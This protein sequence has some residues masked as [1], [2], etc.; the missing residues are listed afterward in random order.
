M[1]PELLNVFTFT[2][3]RGCLKFCNDLFFQMERIKRFYTVSNHKAGFIR[4]WHGHIRERKFIMPIKG[5]ML[6][7]AVRVAEWDDLIDKDEIYKFILSEKSPKIL[8][9]P[10]KFAN[11]LCSLTPDAEVIIFSTLDAGDSAKDDF[12][13]DPF[14]WNIWD[15]LDYEG[16]GEKK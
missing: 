1:K 4:A 7:G 14:K 2:D 8:H 3:E 6:V 10:S 5:S 13:F 11:G 12:R 16:Q 9:I 15:C